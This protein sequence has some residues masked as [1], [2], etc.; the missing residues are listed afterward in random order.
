MENAR[1]RLVPQIGGSHKYFAITSTEYA[2]CA[3]GAM[4]INFQFYRCFS[5]DEYKVSAVVAEVKNIA[6]RDAH[7]IGREIF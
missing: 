2:N 4:L 7:G 6:W 3:V 1:I 5:L